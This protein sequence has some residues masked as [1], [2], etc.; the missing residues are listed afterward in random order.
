M[1]Y[2]LQKMVVG[3]LGDGMGLT[4]G[5]GVICRSRAAMNQSNLVKWP[6]VDP[7][8]LGSA[9]LVIHLNTLQGLAN[10]SK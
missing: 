9:N 7:F 2:E 1:T 5:Y 8:A 4:S 10:I 3:G 6:H